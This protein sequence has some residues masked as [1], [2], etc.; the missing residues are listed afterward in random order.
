MT[1][2]DISTSR[3]AE[4]ASSSFEIIPSKLKT[5]ILERDLPSAY[6]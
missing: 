5:H 2:E 6:E 4:V 3:S 1:D